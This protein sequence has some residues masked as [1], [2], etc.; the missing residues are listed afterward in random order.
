MRPELSAVG[1]GADAR[2]VG[3]DRY[4]YAIS[5]G[6]PDVTTTSSSPHTAPAG[7][8]SRPTAGRL[9]GAV[10]LVGA[11][12][13]LGLVRGADLRF[14]WVPLALGLIY[15]VAAAICRS[16]GTLWGPG[17]V[18]AAVGLTEGLWFH[19]HRSADSFEFAELTLLAA[20]TGA[21]VAAGMRAVGVLVSAMSLALAVLL[22][23]AFNLAEA[24]AVPH[25]A[26][27]IW[28]YTGLLAL[29]GVALLAGAGRRSRS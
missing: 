14:Y 9:R 24:Q 16:R 7:T 6:S 17:W 27:N 18:L 12:L 15:L 21:V 22:V 20:G 11:A 3:T 28:L 29:W 1:N 5:V 13:L 8:A 26:G 4:T 10:L 2:G 19:A 25:V 23:G